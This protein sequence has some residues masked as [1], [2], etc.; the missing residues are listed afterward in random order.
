MN[1]DNNHLLSPEE[2]IEAAMKILDQ[3]HLIKEELE[4]EEPEIIGALEPIQAQLVALD[5]NRRPQVKTI[6]ETCPNSVW[7]NS[8]AEVKC[9]CRVMYLIT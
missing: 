6:C 9:Y 5:S 1:Q 2:Q 7:F 4:A 3:S 8:P